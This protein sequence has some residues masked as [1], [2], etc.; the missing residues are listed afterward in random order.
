MGHNCPAL[1]PPGLSPFPPLTTAPSCWIHPPPGFHQVS[2]WASLAPFMAWRNILLLPMCCP[3]SSADPAVCGAKLAQISEVICGK[4]T[5]R[6]LCIYFFFL[7]MILLMEKS[8]NN[9][10]DI[11]RRQR[12]RCE[13]RDSRKKGSQ[14]AGFT[15]EA[16]CRE[17]TALQKER[18]LESCLAVCKNSVPLY[19]TSGS[20][21]QIHFA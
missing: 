5:M 8:Q 15:A 3:C 1:S 7:K 16:S 9:S 18:W 19:S 14:G 20:G 17:T 6:L 2:G 21:K 4:N 13:R 12:R 10:S 11:T